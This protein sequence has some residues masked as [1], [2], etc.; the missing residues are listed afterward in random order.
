MSLPIAPWRPRSPKRGSHDARP[1]VPGR[2]CGGPK[3]QERTARKRV[4]KFCCR[5]RAKRRLRQA[6]GQG[7]QVFD[8][9]DAV[10]SRGGLQDCL[11]DRPIGAAMWLLSG[12]KR[13]RANTRNQSLVTRSG[14]PRL[15]M[16]HC[17]YEFHPRGLVLRDHTQRFKPNTRNRRTVSDKSRRTRPAILSTHRSDDRTP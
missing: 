3:H 8:V 17:R 6:V 10:G 12:V 2:R 4:A 7:H 14:R 1:S 13:T 5:V 11:K 15:S 16:L 9:K